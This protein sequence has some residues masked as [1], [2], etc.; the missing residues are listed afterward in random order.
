MCPRQ[1][2]PLLTAHSP[3]SFRGPI[4]VIFSDINH[5]NRVA[6][7]QKMKF[8]AIKSRNSCMMKNLIRARN[9]E[10]E[11]KNSQKQHENAVFRTVKFGN[12]GS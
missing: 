11:M 5:R 4:K 7:I 1:P 3:S 6:L 12:D 2:I 8:L 9:N 10:D